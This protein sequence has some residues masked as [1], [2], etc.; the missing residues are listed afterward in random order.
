M[1]RR[2]KMTADLEV[3]EGAEAREALPPRAL[4][5]GARHRPAGPTSVASQQGQHKGIAL[6]AVHSVGKIVSLLLLK[7]EI[8]KQ[9]I[10]CILT[11]N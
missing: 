11:L 5:S 1:V 8:E 3:A 6:H 2:V 7:T 4:T 9:C 10:L